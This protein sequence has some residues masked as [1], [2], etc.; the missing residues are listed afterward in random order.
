M[1][2]I[3]LDI[4]GNNDLLKV[5]WRAPAASVAAYQIN[6]DRLVTRAATVRMRLQDLIAAAMTCSTAHRA[7]NVGL[8]M[9]A[10]AVAG[11]ELRDAIFFAE[12]GSNDFDDE[13]ADEWFRSLDE[14]VL[15]VTIDRK[16]YIPWGLVYEGDP[17]VLSDDAADTSIE[18]FGA[19]WCHKYQVSTLYNRIRHTV[20]QKPRMATE[21]RI[22]KLVNQSAWAKAH[23][24]LSHLEQ[25]FIAN[26]FRAT[27]ISSSAAFKKAW[28]TEKGCLD[29]DLLYFFGHASGTALAFGKGDVLTMQDFPVILRRSPPAAHPACLVFLNGCHTAIGSSNEGGFLEATAHPGFCGFVGTEAEVP[30]IFALRLANAFIGELLYIGSTAI[31]AMKKVRRDYWPLSLAY[32]LS[33]HPDFR[34]ISVETM[35]TTLPA[36]NFSTDAVGSNRV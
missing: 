36:P 24:G 28:R 21:A 32:S 27:D 33:C 6:T 35:G 17:E 25:Q 22:M 16:I 12:P 3:I 18:K 7:L 30:D 13:V 29:T 23:L 34:F 20:V 10:L 8:E 19:F 26:M 11:R 15:H 2:D 4:R 14:A 31:N 1:T 5:E 9:K